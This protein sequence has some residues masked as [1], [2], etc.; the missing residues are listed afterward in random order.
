MRE[1]TR[2]LIVDAL[3]R[4]RRP[5]TFNDLAAKLKGKIHP[6]TIRVL[7]RHD[8]ELADALRVSLEKADRGAAQIYLAGAPADD[9]KGVPWRTGIVRTGLV[10]RTARGRRARGIGQAE[11]LEALTRLRNGDGERARALSSK[12]AAL[13]DAAEA[14]V[15]ARTALATAIAAFERLV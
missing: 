14:V 2:E 7:A 4:A 15:R 13:L 6:N 11:A 12:A 9:G 3:K 8:A 1:K 10:P 5:M